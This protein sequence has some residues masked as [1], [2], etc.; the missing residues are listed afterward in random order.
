MTARRSGLHHRDIPARPGPGVFDR[1]SW[2][3]VLGSDRLEEGE[4]VLGAVGCPQ[5]EQMVVLVG[6]RSAAAHRHE[7]GVADRRKDHD[8]AAAWRRD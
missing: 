1:L 8:R 7:A 2:S 6:E 3:G 4:D 5:G